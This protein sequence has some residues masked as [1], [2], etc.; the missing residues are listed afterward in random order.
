MILSMLSK[1]NTSK[2][3]LSEEDGFCGEDAGCFDSS[4][5]EV[6]DKPTESARASRNEESR[7]NISFALLM[8]KLLEESDS[9]EMFAKSSFVGENFEKRVSSSSGSSTL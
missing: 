8:P 1:S 9:F 3:F 7:F 6:P 4:V 2:I 5:F